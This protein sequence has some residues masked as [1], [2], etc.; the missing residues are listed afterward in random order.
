MALDLDKEL[1]PHL[2]HI[3]PFLRR[4]PMTE[5][6]ETTLYHVITQAH[7]TMMRLRLHLFWDPDQPSASYI[8][9]VLKTFS[10]F[11]NHIEAPYYHAD[12]ALWRLE[13]EEFFVANLLEPWTSP[14]PTEVLQEDDSDD[15]IVLSRNNSN[16]VPSTQGAT[17]TP[18]P[19]EGPPSTWD[20]AADAR[21]FSPPRVRRQRPLPGKRPNPSDL[22][23]EAPPA[24]KTRGGKSVSRHSSSIQHP[25]SSPYNASDRSP[26]PGSSSLY[27]P[28]S[29]DVDPYFES[30]DEWFGRPSPPCVASLGHSSPPLEQVGTVDDEELESAADAAQEKK[31]EE[32]EDSSSEWEY[33]SDSE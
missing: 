18:A 8:R 17:G 7:P 16:Q 4:E 9:D 28:D 23:S 26:S 24:K 10:I 21:L 11:A 13:Q 20:E 6:M 19:V 29:D 30:N 27:N 1:K 31:E 3:Q 14:P 22:E 12:W 5:D 15:T 33:S 32:E 25:L 2:L